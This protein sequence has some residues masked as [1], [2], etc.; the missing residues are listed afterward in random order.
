MRIT[1]FGAER[2]QSRI[3]EIEDRL[4][5]LFHRER[6]SPTNPNR[7]REQ[8]HLHTS[9][10]SAAPLQPLN[11]FPSNL[12]IDVQTLLENANMVAD[13]FGLDRNIFRALISA[14]SGWNP[15]SVSP[16][17]AQG[18]TQLMPSTAQALG[19]LDPFDPIQNLRGG[20]KYLRQ[21][22][23]EFGSYE[24]ALAAYNAGPGAVKRYGG[25]PPYPETQNYVRKILSE[26]ER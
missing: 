25:I 12:S 9:G 14:E 20:A 10:I 22:L 2:I 6:P 26:V 18:L 7:L 3:R 16:K 1:P 19:V 4:K 24:L 15:N 8:F 11:V 17:G 23:D 5:T 13:E 21:M